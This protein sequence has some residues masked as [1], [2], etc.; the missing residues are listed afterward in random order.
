MPTPL[1]DEE[2]M[3][4]GKYKGTKMKDVPSDYLDWLIGQPWISKWPR[5]K[6]YIE[7]NKKSIEEDIPDEELPF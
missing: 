5:V 4:F 6:L 2:P 7:A 1:H 3:P